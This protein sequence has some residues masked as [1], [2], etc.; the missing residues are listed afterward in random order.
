MEIT[1]MLKFGNISK[2]NFHFLTYINISL[3]FRI[4]TSNFL[5]KVSFSLI[6]LTI[7]FVLLMR[8]A[9]V[10]SLNISW[11]VTICL[12]P[13]STSEEGSLVFFL[14]FFFPLTRTMLLILLLL[15][16]SWYASFFSFY[17]S[18]IFKLS[19]S[20]HKYSQSGPSLS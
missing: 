10:N 6:Y 8:P 9:H 3:P 1:K 17:L 4:W 7:C 2:L 11:R 19:S 5:G 13:F 15:T 16:S 14:F 12:V 20:T 18:F